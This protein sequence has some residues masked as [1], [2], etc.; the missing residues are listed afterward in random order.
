[1][2]DPRLRR[3]VLAW[4]HRDAQAVCTHDG[5]LPPMKTLFALSAWF[6][7]LV[8]C[9]PLAVRALVWWPRIW[10]L[11]SPRRRAGFTCSAPARFLPA[12]LMLPARVLGG[13]PRGAVIRDW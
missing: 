13:G 5:G 6:V 1:S 9:W 3:I 12:L 7:L 11:S 4:R 10:R 2:A 8:F